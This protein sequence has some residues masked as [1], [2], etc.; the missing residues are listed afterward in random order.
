MSTICAREYPLSSL[1]SLLIWIATHVQWLLLIL[2]DWLGMLWHPYKRQFWEISIQK[3][4]KTRAPNFLFPI[5]NVVTTIFSSILPCI[6]S[7]S[8]LIIYF[9]KIKDKMYITAICIDNFSSMD[10]LNLVFKFRYDHPI[11][12]V[13]FVRRFVQK[14]YKLTYIFFLGHH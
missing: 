2:V 11:M 1:V 12:Y 8:A 5:N 3:R 13:V 14:K 10:T 7:K 6:V 4:I 9:F